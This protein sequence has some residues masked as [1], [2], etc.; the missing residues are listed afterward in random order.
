[1]QGLDVGVT[2]TKS[3]LAK[4]NSPIGKNRT[5][6]DFRAISNSQLSSEN[7]V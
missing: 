7:L 2:S 1:M 3:D 5:W 6:T 4:V